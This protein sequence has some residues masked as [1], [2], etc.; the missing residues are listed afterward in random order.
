MSGLALILDRLRSLEAPA[1]LAT[2]V[3]TRGSSYRRP[4]ARMILEPG[5]IHAGV[6]SA[7]CL[8]AD[9]LARVEAVLAS[10]RPTLVTYELGTDLDRI[11]GTGMGCAGR[12]DILLE[13]VRP[14]R[15]PPW[16]PFTD[17]RLERRSPTVLAALFDVTARAC[18]EGASLLPAE[19]DVFAYDDRAH[20][21]LPMDQDVSL[22]LHRLAQASL[23]DGKTRVERVDLPQ[24]AFSVLVE[25]VLPP[26]ALWI[27]GAGENAR[28]MADLA[29]HLGFEV[30]ILDHRPA[31]VTPERFPLAKHHVLAPLTDLPDAVPDDPKAAALVMSH[32]FEADKAMV[33]ALVPK[34]LAY[35]G[36]QGNRKR[37]EKLLAEL[38]AEG[39]HLEEAQRQR[40]FA[41]MG[42]DLGGDGPEAIALSV[43]AEVQAVLHQRTVLPL[44]D[45][46]G[47]IHP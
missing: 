20:G 24:V 2:L 30:G 25:A 12:A 28:P 35:V 6:L 46:L 43:L 15:I 3:Q 31:L 47:P 26:P 7:G 11:W 44:R 41:P 29:A 32:V 9:L 18:G 1:V 38:A 27:F 36:L 42:L 14:G 10:D 45:S 13:P 22:A 37:T 17:I 5:R 19:G 39:F 23:A 4:G 33:R 40:L 21:L 34:N 8:E 16:I